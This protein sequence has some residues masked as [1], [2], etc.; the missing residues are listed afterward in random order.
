MHR[1]GRTIAAGNLSMP[2]WLLASLASASVLVCGTALAQGAHADMVRAH[3][4]S[5]TKGDWS[6]FNEQDY[7]RARTELYISCMQQHGLRP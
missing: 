3:C 6:D 5:A 4:V 7:G 2:R 1:T